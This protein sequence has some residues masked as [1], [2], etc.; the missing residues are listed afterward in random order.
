MTGNNRNLAGYQMR[1]WGRTLLFI[2]ALAV[3]ALVVSGLG[4]KFA[5]RCEIRQSQD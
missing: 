5:A 3:L 2:A 4:A 1:P